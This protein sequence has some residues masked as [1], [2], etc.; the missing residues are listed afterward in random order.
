MGVLNIKEPTS[1]REEQNFVKQLLTDVKVL[2][3]MLERGIFNDE[4][5][6][7]GAEQEVCLIDKTFRASP[8]NIEIL[9]AA[10]HPMLT[11]ELAKFNL[12]FNAKPREFKGSC[13]QDMEDDIKVFQQRQ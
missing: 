10:N 13:F 9:E 8:K 5:I 12:E 4:I 7:I 11:P 3:E 1:K 6:R 2:D